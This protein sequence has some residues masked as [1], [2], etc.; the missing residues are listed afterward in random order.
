MIVEQGPQFK[1]DDYANAIELLSKNE[2]PFDRNIL[3]LRKRK[4]HEILKEWGN[5]KRGSQ[6]ILVTHS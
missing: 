4:L 6:L 5:K 1:E 2:V 3:E